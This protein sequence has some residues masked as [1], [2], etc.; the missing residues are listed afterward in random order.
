MEYFQ[1]ALIV[2]VLIAAISNTRKLDEIQ[3]KIK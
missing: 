1:L 2:A 3:R